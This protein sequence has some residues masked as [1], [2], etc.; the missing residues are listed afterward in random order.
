MSAIINALFG[1]Y[2]DTE[3]PATPNVV[4]VTS[5]DHSGAAVHTAVSD[6][7]RVKS[8]VNTSTT[9]TVNLQSQ[10][11]I[12]E[13]MR[14]LGTTH[15]QVD[16]YAKRR[17]EEISA[18]VAANIQRIVTET[19]VNQQLLLSDAHVQSIQ[20]EE[21]Y[22]CALQKYVEELDAKKASKLAQLER[23][24]NVRQELMLELAKK[25]IDQ[26]NDA[27]NQAK[28]NILKDAQE[29][30]NMQ[31]NQITDQVALLGAEDAQRRLQSTT[32]T[33]ITTNT[34]ATSNIHAPTTAVDV[35]Q[36]AAN[37]LAAV[38]GTVIETEKSTHVETTTS[39]TTDSTTG[40]NQQHFTQ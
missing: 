34:N 8:V 31:I 6:D 12:D 28:M 40:T 21:E 5:S 19:Q 20:I 15:S 23:D 2:P 29:H 18:D 22:K 11:K 27:A 32:T 1:T 10:A 26:L 25:Q 13:L 4:E 35:H 17:T 30:A 9:T 38:S 33:V 16:E 36:Q 14:K 37:N 39:S 3:N 24:L 7:V